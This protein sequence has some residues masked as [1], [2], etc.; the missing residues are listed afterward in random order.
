MPEIRSKEGDLVVRY[1]GRRLR[2]N[3]EWADVNADQF[4]TLLRKVPDEI[5]IRDATGSTPVEAAPD[6]GGSPPSSETAPE[7]GASPPGEAPP[8]S[9]GSPP[10][11]EAPPEKK[12][13]RKTSARR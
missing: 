6:S 1:A 3:E 9:G 7:S 11:S 10:T 12:S 5:E 8:D 4:E 13:K 2:I